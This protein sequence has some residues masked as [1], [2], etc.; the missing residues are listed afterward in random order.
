MREAGY[1]YAI[2]GAAGP[3]AFYEQLVGATR[4]PGS[5]PGPYRGLLRDPG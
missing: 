1:A 4:I 2:I 5:R 3:I